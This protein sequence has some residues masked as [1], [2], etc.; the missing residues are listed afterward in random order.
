MRLLLIITLIT[1]PSIVLAADFVPI[2]PLPTNFENTGS[3]EGYINGIFQLSISI[4]AVL[5]VLRIIWGG[6]KYM[7]EEAVNA[8]GEA[9]QVIQ[10]ALLGLALLL[11]S[12]LILYVINPNLVNLDALKFEKL[13]S[14]AP[15]GQITTSPAPQNSSQSSTNTPPPQTPENTSST[16][17]NY[18]SRNEGGFLNPNLVGYHGMSGDTCPAYLQIGQRAPAPLSE[19][20]PL[21]KCKPHPDLKSCCVYAD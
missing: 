15:S 11:G 8:K 21:D 13:R 3:L 16:R 6:F 5:A 18:A 10:Q 17:L 20:A 1:L 2:A 9:R 4:G 14:D 12:W 7:T 19:S